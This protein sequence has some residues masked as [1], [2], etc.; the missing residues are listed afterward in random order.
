MLLAFRFGTAM[1][2][3]NTSQKFTRP[4]PFAVDHYSV[5]YIVKLIVS[6]YDIVPA[7]LADQCGNFLSS[8]LFT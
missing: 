5:D 6:N 2:R 7:R 1:M 3:K 8:N 4:D